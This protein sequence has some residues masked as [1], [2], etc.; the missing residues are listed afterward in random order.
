MIRRPITGSAIDA[1]PDEHRPGNHAQGHE[2][3]DP[4]VVAVGDQCGA[5]QAPSAGELHLRRDLVAGEADDPRRRQH[6]EMIE[7]LRVQKPIDGNGKRVAGRHEDRE[8]DERPASSRLA[9]CGGRTRSRAAPPSARRRSCAPGRPAARPSPTQRRS[10]L[11]RR[12]GA[13]DGQAD[14]DGLRPVAGTDDRPVHQAM[15]L[16]ARATEIRSGRRPVGTGGNH[17]ISERNKEWEIRRDTRAAGCWE[18][19]CIFY[20]MCNAASHT[21]CDR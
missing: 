12:H 5:R 21:S 7:C 2:A 10:Q 8:H 1:E 6:P 11:D 19:S 20:R 18:S 17:H 14:R 9:S 4:G 13:Q 16:V 15:R 3:V